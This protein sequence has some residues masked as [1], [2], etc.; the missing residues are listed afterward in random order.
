MAAVEEALDR[1]LTTKEYWAKSLTDKNVSYGL[2]SSD[3]E[4]L[5]CN[6]KEAKLSHLHISKE[7]NVTKS[8]SYTTLTGEKNGD[9][10]VE[11][12]LKTPIGVYELNKKIKELDPFYGPLALVTNYPNKY[13]R[14]LK[15]SG[16]GIWIHGYPMKGSRNPYT[17]GCLAL[18]NKKLL[19]LN[20]DINYT[21]TMLVI[22]PNIF[23]LTNQ[24][25]ISTILS[26]LF[27]WRKAWKESRLA[28]YLAFYHNDF[29]RSNGLSLTQFSI[30]KQ[31]IFKNK[32]KRMINFY[33]ISIIPYP[34]E[35]M[36]KIFYI[37]LKEKYKAG[38]IH[39]NG[40]KELYLE[41]VNNKISIL[42][43]N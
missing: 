13:D 22:S 1:Q 11:G 8:T 6:K 16:S 35:D 40:N 31:S 32:I 7:H 5:F 23:P 29:K 12:D 10:Q 43:E 27:S 19:D 37:T 42:T 33:N 2:F 14:S 38:R 39:F 36:R 3:K 15:K 4:L 18:K 25:E 34:N 26:N 9:K 24:D 17:K 21:N 30:I 20:K 28:S 41:L